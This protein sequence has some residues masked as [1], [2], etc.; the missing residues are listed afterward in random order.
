MKLII[1]DIE[2]T[3]TPIDFVKKVLFPFSAKYL[4]DYVT[5]RLD[6]NTMQKILMQV[7]QTAKEEIGM[8]LDSKAAIQMLLQ[9]IEEDRK[10]PALK[11]IQGQMWREGYASGVFTSEVYDDVPPALRRWHDAGNTLCVYSSGSVEAQ[12]DLF[13]YTNAGDLSGLFRYFFDTSVG[14]KQEVQSYINI[15]EKTQTIG[16]DAL[17][18]SDI[19]A[20]L[21]AAAK[22]GI[23][24]IQVLRAGTIPG[25]RHSTAADFGDVQKMVF[26]P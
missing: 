24:T 20:E 23:K 16:P 3:T 8:S 9:W 15:L 6:L 25:T 17:F 10:H 18:L 19:E 13:K 5:A 22:A 26:G 7:S 1:T 14:A 21:D 11:T 2:G 12:K 4:E